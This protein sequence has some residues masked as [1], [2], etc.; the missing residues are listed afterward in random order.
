M[1][2]AVGPCRVCSAQVP[3]L[4]V[5]SEAFDRIIRVI[6]SGSKTLGC[7]ELKHTVGCTD[8][9]A[10]AWIT[11]L[12]SCIGVWA[13]TEDDELVLRDL[14]LAFAGIAKPEHFTDYTHCE[15]CEEHDNTLRSR[16]RNSIQRE[17]L[18][19]AGWD[20]MSFCSA[21]GMG[22][23][24]PALARMAMLPPIWP[25]HDWYG[26][27]LL[28]HLTYEGEQNKFLRWCTLHRREAVVAFLRHFQKTRSFEYG[29]EEDIYVALQLWS[30]VT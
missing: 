7:L 24:F 5:G 15:E 18:G 10:S 27:Q 12:M 22:Y 11:H 17:D 2:A 26:G 28:F 19:N 9:E 3:Q 25:D 14:D 6:S 8:K 30:A 16:T 23:F 20:P 4:N 21:E 29:C 1:A 13:G